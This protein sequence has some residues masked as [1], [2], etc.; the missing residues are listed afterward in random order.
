MLLLDLLAEQRIEQ[1]RDAG[2]FDNL[3]GAGQPLPEE[4]LSMVPEDERVAFRILKNA[5]YIPP[6]LEMHKRA[7]DLALQLASESAPETRAGLL[8]RLARINI[9]LAEAGKP[10]LCVPADYQAR[11]AERL[12]KGN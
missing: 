12:S 10:Q 11:L 5:G 4:D 6:E 1:A 9:L 8:G 2:A 3:P 7:V